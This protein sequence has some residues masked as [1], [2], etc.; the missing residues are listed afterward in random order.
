M[1]TVKSFLKENL[2]RWSERLDAKIKERGLN[3][4]TLSQQ[5]SIS[6]TTIQ[7]YLDN[8]LPKSK[9]LDELADFFGVTTDW[10]LGRDSVTQ[11][12]ALRES[13]PEYLVDDAL[14]QVND[15]KEKLQSLERIVKQIKKGKL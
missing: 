13:P 7:N 10:L 6:H 9:H 3:P 8:N 15:L 14:A 1:Q 2:Q 5:L 4:W 11:P 12:M